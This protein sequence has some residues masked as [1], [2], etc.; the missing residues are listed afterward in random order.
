VREIS[1]QERQRRAE[2]RRRALRYP[3]LKEEKGIPYSR[4]HI[5]RLELAGKFPKHFHFSSHRGSCGWWEHE[6][7][8]HL[9][10]CAAGREEV[11]A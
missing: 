11:T 1:D 2:Q 10:A 3:Q 4:E 7:D 5:R 8:A 6:V 9:E